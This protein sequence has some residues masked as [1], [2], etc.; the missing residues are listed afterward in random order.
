M[1]RRIIA[2]LL[3]LAAFAGCSPDPED[4]GGMIWK[5]KDTAV[6]LRFGGA[7]HFKSGGDDPETMISSLTLVVRPDGPDGWSSAVVRTLDM[8]AME[9]D[10]ETRSCTTVLDLPSGDV[11]FHL[12]ANLTPDMRSFVAGAAGRGGLRTSRRAAYAVPSFS[13]VSDPE[14]FG[15][16]A[17]LLGGAFCPDGAGYVMSGSARAAVGSGSGQ[18]IEVDI[19]LHRMVA[20]VGLSCRT[21]E[22]EPDYVMIDGYYDWDLSSVPEELRVDVPEGSGS[23]A[24]WVPLSSVRWFLDSVNSK[25]FLEAADDCCDPGENA[26]DPNMLLDDVLV[27]SG[28]ET[29]YAA[30]YSGDF[31]HVGRE[32]ASQVF[33]LYPDSTPSWMAH[34]VA[35]SDEP[36]WLVCPENTVASDSFLEG[37]D[38]RSDYRMLAPEKA[39]THLLVEARFIP[40]YVISGRMRGEEWPRIYES[41][42]TME[43]AVAALGGDGTFWTPD[44]KSFFTWQGVLDEIAYSRARHAED[45]NIRELREDDFI[46]YPQGMCYYSTYVDGVRVQDAGLPGLEHVTYWDGL[47]S[48]RRDHSYSVVASVMRVPSVSTSMIEIRTAVSTGW[49]DGYGDVTVKP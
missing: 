43:A 5:A 23:Q 4:E 28:R 20:R 41:Y 36:E 6:V 16:M 44:L 42:A 12:F 18:E 39:V 7:P 13:A 10:G 11:V 24:G 31:L 26:D 9:D 33:S 30:A 49:L 35:D 14:D 29:A 1:R 37:E 40:R 19:V 27:Q 3:L 22:S 45:P 46:C 17:Q 25:V 32:S 8:D 21:Y 15:N 38:E 48:V 2:A 47:S 34:A